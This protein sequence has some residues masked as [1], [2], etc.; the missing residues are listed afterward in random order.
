[1]YSAGV[2]AKTV[3][4][5][6]AV[7]GDLAGWKRHKV[8]NLPS[9][10]TPPPSQGRALGLSLIYVRRWGRENAPSVDQ[11]SCIMLGFRH[12]LAQRTHLPTGQLSECRP[13]APV[14]S[15]SLARALVPLVC[16][17]S[18]GGGAVGAAT[19]PGLRWS[20][21]SRP[22]RR[23]R[24]QGATLDVVAQSNCASVCMCTP[25]HYMCRGSAYRRSLTGMLRARLW[26]P[27]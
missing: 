6:C 11:R 7:F 15:D 27:R 2:A 14:G 24:R 13:S 19:A 21:S 1:M 20:T 17:E 23:S 25:A 3:C 12:M 8:L 18:H 4:V 26:F 22:T 5:P 16:R 9:F 10:V